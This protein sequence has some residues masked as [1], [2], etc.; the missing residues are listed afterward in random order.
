MFSKFVEYFKDEEDQDPTFIRMTRNILLFVILANTALLPLVAGLLGEGSK[1]LPAFIILVITLVLE[2]IS[3]TNVIRGKVGM[4]KAVVPLSLIVA[5]TVIS[6]N[7]NGLKNSAI[8]SFPIILMIA[9]I[10][11]GRRVLPIATPL[12]ILALIVIA[13]EDLGGRIPFVATGL[14]DAI[15]LPVLLISTAGIINLLIVRL[16]DSIQRAKESERAHILENAELVQLRA[17][18]EE[19]VKQR[20]TEL[21][22]A[23]QT[24]DRRARQFQAVA[25]VMKAI[26]TI[27]DLG[28]LLP[29]VTQVIS[30]QFNIY[31]TGIFLL[32]AQRE[33]AVLRASNSEGGQRMLVRGHKLQVGQTGIVG[34]VT[35]TGQP[36]IA[37]DVGADA[38]YFDNPDLPNTHSEIAL[39]LRYAGVIIGALDVQSTEPNAFNREDVDALVTLADQVAIAINNAFTIEQAQQSLA[40]ARSALGETVRQA[41]QV[42]RPKS[43]GLGVR[44][45]ESTVKPLDEP[46][47]GH[48]I[49]EAI[50]KG[51]SILSAYEGQRANLAVP[52]RLRDQIVGVL[53]ISAPKGLTLTEDEIDIAEAISERLSLAIESATLLQAAQQRADVERVTTDITSRIGSSTRFETILQTAAKELSKALG[54]S[55]VIVQI[56]AAAM[57]IAS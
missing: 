2:S 23:N 33:Y 57:E 49:Q 17:S 9:A 40:E 26:S 55:D 28:T 36:R 45:T 31:H 48:H 37:L 30:E 5:S 20:T 46:L 52:I 39:P 44:L 21:E 34:F 10:L 32:D 16:N 3:L 7:T 15:I 11:L 24:N 56:E 18:L 4:A 25:Q 22:V 35:A 8:I 29:R 51:R 1:N 54:G 19:R 41:W 38:V 6:L 13:F 47:E 50:K 42:M 12:V 53:Q 27:Q 14:D 43:L